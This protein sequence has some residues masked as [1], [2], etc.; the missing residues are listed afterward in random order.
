MA[1]R[2]LLNADEYVPHQE[3]AL[4]RA[5]V[6][7]VSGRLVGIMSRICLPDI[8]ATFVGK[9]EERVATRKDG[10]PRADFNV[11]RS[12]ALKLCAGVVCVACSAACW[13]SSSGS[14]RDSC[15]SAW[16][17][18]ATLELQAL[19]RASQLARPCSHAAAAA[20]MRHVVLSFGDDQQL[21]AATA[22]L[23]KAHPLNYTAAVKKSQVGAWRRVVATRACLQEQ[24]HSH[25][26][27]VTHMT[28]GLCMPQRAQG[29]MHAAAPVLLLQVHHALCEM[30][31]EVLAP[32]IRSNQPQASLQGLSAGAVCDWYNAVLKLKNEVGQ[33]VNKHSKHTNVRLGLARGGQGGGARGWAGARKV[34]WW[35]CLDCCL[36]G[37]CV[38]S[39]SLLVPR[40]Q[41]GYPL[42]TVLVCLVD[43]ANYAKQVESMAD[44]LAKQM[45]VKEY[46]CGCL[47]VC[48]WV[49]SCWA[50]AGFTTRADAPHVL[51]RRTHPRHPPQAAVLQVPGLPGDLVPGAPQGCG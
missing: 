43:E 38:L 12:Q 16:R 4:V 34:E 20:G 15:S 29:C 40:M 37:C 27:T 31:T 42:V 3:L 18:R 30:L 9:L 50:R 17:Q 45:R 11:L 24:E 1:F 2:W 10:A 49:A 22:F 25:R 47:V 7:A 51:C 26:S 5:H 36:W 44:F 28:R 13:H 23:H 6:V 41:V 8:S 32:L 48:T 46:R 14:S 19:P 35:G 21:Q 39:A 33:W